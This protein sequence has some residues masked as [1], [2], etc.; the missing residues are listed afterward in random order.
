VW[1]RKVYKVSSFLADLSKNISVMH[2]MFMIFLKD[3]S[4][5]MLK[6]DMAK[7]IL[8]RDRKAEKTQIKQSEDLLS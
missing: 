3:F 5:S 7:S 8:H 1:E 2:F 6:K 4:L